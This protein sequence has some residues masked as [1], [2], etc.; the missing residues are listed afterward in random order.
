MNDKAQMM[1]LEAIFFAITAIIALTFLI[2]ISPTSIESSDQPSSELKTLGEDALNTIYSETMNITTIEERKAWAG[3][4]NGKYTTNNPTSKL[5][6]CIIT[7]NYQELTDSLNITLPNTVVYNIYVSNGTKT[8]F[9][10]SS[11]G[12]K[13]G[14][15]PSKMIGS[16]TIS[17]HPISIDP[18]HLNKFKGDIYLPNKGAEDKYESDIFDDFVNVMPP[19]FGSTYE[20]ILEMSYIWT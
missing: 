20:V 1:V 19:Y 7:N 16:V 9:W 6:V 14:G 15:T 17:H 2:Q 13:H 11:S 8:V 10:C 3:V 18:V 12:A 5:A 4:Y